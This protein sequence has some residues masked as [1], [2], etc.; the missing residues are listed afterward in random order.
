M[1]RN[2]DRKYERDSTEFTHPNKSQATRPST[3]T[4]SPHKDPLAF[5]EDL[6]R[7]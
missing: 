6:D 1:V 7:L 3:T 4:D 2:L 5:D